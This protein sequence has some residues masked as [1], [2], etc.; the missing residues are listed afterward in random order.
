MYE[1]DLL[2]TLGWQHVYDPSGYSINA[3]LPDN[4]SLFTWLSLG[5]LHTVTNLTLNGNLPDLPDSWASNGSFPSLL[6]MNFSE[7]DLG[8]SLPSSWSSSSAFPQLS[9]LSFNAT[10]L[11]GTLSDA[12]G[13]PGSFSK[14]TELYLDHTNIT[15]ATQLTILHC[16]SIAFMHHVLAPC[17]PAIS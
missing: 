4:C 12:W 8:G 3:S 5:S 15:G 14:L 7:T 16:L 11:S 10:H 9:T 6:A 13:Q 17:L 2:T 1:L